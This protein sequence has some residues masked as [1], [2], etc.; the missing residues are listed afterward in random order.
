MDDIY[1]GTFVA[2]NVPYM[3]TTVCLANDLSYSY[4]ILL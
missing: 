3:D 1:Y 4:R 2:T